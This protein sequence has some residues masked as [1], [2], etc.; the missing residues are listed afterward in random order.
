MVRAMAQVPAWKLHLETSGTWKGATGI[1]V[2]S[3]GYAVTLESKGDLAMPRCIRLDEAALARASERV[4]W[5][6]ENIKEGASSWG[7]SCNDDIRVNVY[8][9]NG[10]R[11]Q[12]L[13]YPL[14]QSCRD[15][16]N[17]PP[18]ALQQLVEELLE[19]REKASERCNAMGA[20]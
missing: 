2:D 1:V 16:Q 9:Q 6:G 13:R 10:E 8:L 5:L 7:A 17:E 20:R 4:S 12:L 18:L 15:P 3:T 11:A 19:L 14:Q